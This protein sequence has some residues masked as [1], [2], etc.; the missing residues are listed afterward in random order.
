[1]AEE[2]LSKE[3]KA[4]KKD[5]ASL[6]NPAIEFTMGTFPLTGGIHAILKTRVQSQLKEKE[7]LFFEEL[8]NGGIELTEN[9]I[10]NDDFLF[11]FSAAATAAVAAI[12][13]EK[14]SRF[15]RLLAAVT[16]GEIPTTDEYEGLLK[17]LDA[18]SEVEWTF[19]LILYRYQPKYIPFEM[20]PEKKHWQEMIT[21]ETW[22]ELKKEIQ[23]ACKLDDFMLTSMV[24]HLESL[25]CILTIRGGLTLNDSVCLSLE[26]YKLKEIIERNSIKP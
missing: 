22:D 14:I 8:S 2:N 24:A 4:L 6:T 9:L 13:K 26:F 18:L 17:M 19:L 12:S 3:L 11:R 7:K 10:K 16:C 1:M 5:E 21:D 23:I 15:A 20:G 25:G